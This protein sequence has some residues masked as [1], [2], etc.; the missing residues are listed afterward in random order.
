MK[1]RVT[2][3]K[4]RRRLNRLERELIDDDEDGDG[5]GEPDP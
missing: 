2:F 3:Q 4:V 1:R 5:G